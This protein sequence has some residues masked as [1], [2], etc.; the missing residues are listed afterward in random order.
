LKAGLS[1]GF[2][3]VL[4]KLTY[5]LSNSRRCGYT[6]TSDLRHVLDAARIWPEAD[7]RKGGVLAEVH[8]VPA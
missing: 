2:D 6:K 7:D 1:R 4:L 5:L 8:D 3:S